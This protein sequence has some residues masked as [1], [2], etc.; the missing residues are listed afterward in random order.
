[1]QGEWKFYGESGQLWQVGN[2]KDNQ[3]H[4]KWIRYNKQ[5]HLE[6][7]EFFINGKIIKK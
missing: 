7:D 5:E 1:M 3:K 2:F 6:Y 4:G